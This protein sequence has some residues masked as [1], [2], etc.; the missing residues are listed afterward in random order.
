M[1]CPN[2]YTPIYRQ[3][4]GRALMTCLSE[5][6]LAVYFGKSLIFT[7]LLRILSSLF[8]GHIKYHQPFIG[9]GFPVHPLIHAIDVDLLVT[10]GEGNVF[11]H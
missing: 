4:K 6:V 5:V 2:A 11:V 1:F 3:K 8:E 9:P 10:P 7:N